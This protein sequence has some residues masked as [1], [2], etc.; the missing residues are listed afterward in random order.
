MAKEMR[1]DPVLGG[2]HE[3]EVENKKMERND[4]Y[5][6]MALCGLLI[7][8]IVNFF[9]DFSRDRKIAAIE[10]RL[11]IPN[12]KPKIKEV[13]TDAKPL[14][15]QEKEKYVDEIRRLREQIETEKEQVSYWRIR[16]LEL[17]DQIPK[18]KKK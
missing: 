15:N 13:N 3:V 8:A 18:E 6:L 14:T 10:N 1:Q 9:S 2:W 11:E 12:E 4:R 17:Y 16:Y 7:C 5:V